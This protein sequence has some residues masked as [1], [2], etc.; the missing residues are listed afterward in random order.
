MPL[1]SLL[2]LLLFLLF[3]IT[4]IITLMNV[5]SDVCGG[6]GGVLAVPLKN[7]A[8]ANVDSTPVLGTAYIYRTY[9]TDITKQ[10]IYITVALNGSNNSGTGQLFYQEPFPLDANADVT[11]DLRIDVSSS[12]Y[13]WTDAANVT[14]KQYVNP[15]MFTGIYSCFTYVFNLRRICDP[16]RSYKNPAKRNLNEV[17]TCRPEYAG[18]CDPIDISAAPSI[19]IVLNVNGVPYS[20]SI[21]QNASNATCP[22]PVSSTAPIVLTNQNYVTQYSL[23]PSAC[24]SRPPQPP[25]PPPP[26]SPPSPPSPPRPPPPSP[27][28]PPAVPPPP[29][30][31]PDLTYSATISL[32]TFDRNRIFSSGYDCFVGRNATAAYYRGRVTVQRIQCAIVSV[33]QSAL[34]NDF[35]MIQWTYYFNSV[36]NLRYF[37]Q[38]VNIETF[39]SDL[40]DALVPGCGAVGNYTDS[41]FNRNNAPPVPLAQQNLANPQP[42][43]SFGGVFSRDD[44]CTN[45]PVGTTAASACIALRLALN[46][47]TMNTTTWYCDLDRYTSNYVA[48]YTTFA[49]F[50]DANMFWVNFNNTFFAVATLNRLNPDCRTFLLATGSPSCNT[51]DVYWDV[52]NS[53]YPVLSDSCGPAPPRP[54]PRASSPPPPVPP[55]ISPAPPNSWPPGGAPPIPPPPPS[56]PPPPYAAPMVLTISANQPYVTG[57]CAAAIKSLS[58][59]LA[60][61]DRPFQGPVCTLGQTIAYF[62]VVTIGFSDYRHAISFAMTFNSEFN[63]FASTIGLACGTTGTIQANGALYNLA[64]PNVTT[65]C[66]NSPPRPPF[67]PSPRPSPRPPNVRS[68]PP[69]PMPPSPGSPTE[70]GLPFAPRIRKPP[71]PPRPPSPRPPS[72]M[73]LEPAMP[74]VPPSPPPPDIPIPPES[75]LTPRMPAPV[76]RSPRPPPPKRPS[77][78]PPP[79][80]LRPPPPPP[81]QPPSLP[82]PPPPPPRRSPP[83]ARQPPP[84]PPPPPSSP[85]PPNPAVNP[86]LTQYRTIAITTPSVLAGNPVT[87]DLLPYLCTNLKAGLRSIF[88]VYG[89]ESNLQYR[90]PLEYCPT[91]N[92]PNGSKQYNVTIQLT[93]SAATTLITNLNSPSNFQLF[94]TATDILC[95]SKVS[96]LKVATQEELFTKSKDVAPNALDPDDSFSSCVHSLLLMRK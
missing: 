19:F 78:P 42:F 20:A 24:A 59:K 36:D 67:P 43:C 27:P 22:S 39:W 68:P 70:P 64:C 46:V 80:R 9:S 11:E 87:T 79:R 35:D 30:P 90:I 33:Y 95:A 60:F 17:C 55:V 54:P 58:A 72:P 32:M 73:P 51:S 34:D 41:F 84:S 66:C 57:I 89:W 75:P 86:Q 37:F 4:L 76:R 45:L 44:C 12:I 63:E 49:N 16:V 14:L 94:V 8:A 74:G 38:S 28:L 71:P 15:M 21:L 6:P 1:A 88:T 2:L 10:L 82:P 69:S 47:Y 31:P 56:S 61:F 93:P 5:F 40:Y 18:N 91:R 96:V 29:R 25:I 50:T 83:P 48:V 26:P 65:F 7:R 23:S 52:R 13:I 85:P 62:M 53:Y 81:Q 77:P 3:T 92:L